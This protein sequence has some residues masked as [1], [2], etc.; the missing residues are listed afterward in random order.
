[1]DGIRIVDESF[2]T[3]TTALQEQA[4]KNALQFAQSAANSFTSAA[5]AGA[6]WTDRRGIA[7]RNLFGRASQTGDR[8]VMTFGGEAPNYK[9]YTKKAK[10]RYPDYMELLEF[11]NGRKYAVIYPLVGD[12]KDD[13][14]AQFGN[15]ILQG[16]GKI[17][18]NRSA[19]AM[20]QRRK[21]YRKRTGR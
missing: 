12:I 6:P 20:K 3:A 14:R 2:Q 13:I 21:E 1:M 18:L 17:Q 7:R 5:K 16:T 4:R 8:T 19:S 10:K 9:P 15:A 11:S